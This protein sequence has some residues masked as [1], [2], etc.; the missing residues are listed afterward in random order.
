MAHIIMIM[1][2]PGTINAIF[3]Q[4]NGI[5]QFGRFLAIGIFGLVVIV[6]FGSMTDPFGG[7]IRRV[8]THVQ[9]SG[10]GIGTQMQETI[11]A[12]TGASATTVVGRIGGRTNIIH[13]QDIG[14]ELGSRI[15]VGGDGGFPTRTFGRRIGRFA[16][17]VRVVLMMRI[18]LMMV[19]A[20][21]SSLLLLMQGTRM[22][23]VQIGQVCMFT[24]G[25]QGLGI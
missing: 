24:V 6:T 25:Q 13:H 7:G 2:S 19:V 5:Q 16:A 10:R 15:T 11:G 1:V 18:S 23:I 20:V 17:I 14:R 8:Q 21:V 9:H 4:N 3:F 22:I 12:G